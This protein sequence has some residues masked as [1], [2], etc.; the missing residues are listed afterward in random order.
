MT[1]ND[2]LSLATDWIAYWQ[3]PEG[4]IEKDELSWTADKEWQLIREAPQH[5]W[6]L[7]L[8]IVKLDPPAEILAAVSAGPLEDLLSYHGEAMIDTVEAEA[9]HNTRFATLLGGVWKNALP[10]A[11]WVRV[12]ALRE[13]VPRDNQSA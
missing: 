2:A 10:H 5:A 4:S 3:A 7:I 1:D 11:V 9:R 8:A 6:K 12:Q 13:T